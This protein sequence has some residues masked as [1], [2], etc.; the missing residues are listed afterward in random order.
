MRAC[1]ANGVRGLEGA[2]CE[3]VHERYQKVSQKDDAQQHQSRK[4]L[5]EVIFMPPRAILA[6][7]FFHCFRTIDYIECLDSRDYSRQLVFLG[8][9]L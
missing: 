9:S 7:G 6:S 5:K 4:T 2:G 8:A 1:L 3:L